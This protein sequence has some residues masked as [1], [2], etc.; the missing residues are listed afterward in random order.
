MTTVP[1]KDQSVLFYLLLADQ[2]C[3]LVFK[4]AA[5]LKNLCVTTNSEAKHDFLWLT[6]L[7]LDGRTPALLKRSVPKAKQHCLNRFYKNA[8]VKNLM[9]QL[10]RQ[11]LGGLVVR[12]HTMQYSV[13][14]IFKD[15]HLP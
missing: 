11:C 2:Y 1:Y 9:Q 6:W 4:Y 10:M 12:R 14:T 15:L 8:A 3:S 13:I 7:S 5:L